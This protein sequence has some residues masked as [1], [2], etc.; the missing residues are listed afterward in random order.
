MLK[1][2]KLILGII[3]LIAIGYFVYQTV[4][5][6]QNK[7]KDEKV[8]TIQRK[9]LQK[10]ISAS[11]KINAEKEIDLKF[12]TS[13]LLTWV[14][15][16]EG[17]MVSAW[18]TIAT[19]DS[20]ELQKSLLKKLRDYSTSRWDFEQGKD[21][22]K[23]N[24]ITDTV[25]RVLE[26]NQFDLDKAVADVEIAEIVL[27][28]SNLT[29]P[30]A[31]IVTQVS[32]PVAGV[33]ITPA[34]AVFT[35]ADPDSLIFTADIDESDIGQLKIGQK[36]QITLDA[37]PEETITGETKTIGFSSVT[38]SGGG[39]A[40]EVKIAL[41]ANHNLKYKIGMNGDVNIILKEIKNTLVLPVNALYNEGNKPY[42][43]LSQNGQKL[44]KYITTGLSNDEEIEIKTGLSSGEKVLIPNK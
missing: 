28:F 41:P 22:Y 2:W 13:G 37:Y 36:S 6:S 31:G 30:I 32:A 20:R 18:Q 15:V 42:V 4:S 1:R 10:T 3:V 14:G 12:Q 7:N 27:K 39:N 11:G 24:V 17:D 29:T 33:N 5:A 19:L 16:K 25:K 34:G 8:I 23:N 40:Y 38:T 35:I 43:Y 26:K 44:K 9:N 21:D